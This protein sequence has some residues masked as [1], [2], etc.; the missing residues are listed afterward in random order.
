MKMLKIYNEIKKYEIDKIDFELTNIG[1]L[2]IKNNNQFFKHFLDRIKYSLTDEYIYI[3]SPKLN[4]YFKIPDINIQDINYYENINNTEFLYPGY[5]FGY[6]P[7][8]INNFS[9]EY[10]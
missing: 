7:V 1:D 8:I 3:Y 9:N 4:K 6:E 2:Y 10:I 5:E